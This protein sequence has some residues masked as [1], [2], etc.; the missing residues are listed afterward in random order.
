MTD[1][2][3]VTGANGLIGKRVVA[4]LR[5]SGWAQPVI[6]TRRQVLSPDG[7][8]QVRLDATDEV[9]LTRVLRNA[10]G[11]VN[12]IT[13]DA[14][15]ILANAHALFAAAARCAV[16]PRVVYL[17]SMA[18][19]GSVTGTVDEF[20][21]LI[22]DGAY[23]AAKIAAEGI[24]A[25]Y[26]GAVILRPGVVYGPHSHWWS[27]QIAHLLSQKRL[28]DLGE[29]GRG[30][31]NLLYVDDMARATLQALRQQ[32]IERRS[33][34]LAMSSP[35]T[36]NEYFGLYANALGT[37]PV[38]RISASR[39]AMELHVLGPALNALELVARATRL[40]FQPPPPIRPWLIHLA[41]QRIRLD[42]SAAERMLDMIWTPIEQALGATAAWFLRRQRQ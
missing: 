23:G 25:T 38:G 16:P 18:V 8:E 39:L 32:G 24:A 15:T 1:R 7:I 27:G 35:P 31:C 26:P 20:A 41:R 33:F 28:G 19:Y 10:T 34:N 3:V 40:P 30:I 11:I 14:T 36:W 12:C 17:S 42:V 4:A 5:A 13:G 2:V 21:P 29:N 22:A 6:A 9:A 37:T